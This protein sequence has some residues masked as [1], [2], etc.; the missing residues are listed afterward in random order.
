[1][2]YDLHVFFY[3][4]SISV[5]DSCNPQL[6]SHQ[7]TSAPNLNCLEHN[8]DNYYFNITGLK[9]AFTRYDICIRYRTALAVGDDKWSAP[10]CI[11]VV[12][13]PTSKF[14]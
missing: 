8:A 7:T 4:Q 11:T 12:T 14:I 1:M 13:K 2:I 5:N 9:Y 6:E 10:S 3:P